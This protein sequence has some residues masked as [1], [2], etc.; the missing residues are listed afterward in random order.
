MATI[1]T[2]DCDLTD[3]LSVPFNVATD[4]TV[5]ADYGAHFAETLIET[6]DLARG[7]EDN[8]C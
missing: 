7:T 8:T 3:L 5:L 1:L 4:L 2:P 6:D